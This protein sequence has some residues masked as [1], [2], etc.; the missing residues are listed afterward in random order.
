MEQYT[1]IG[2]PIPRNDAVEKATGESYYLN[3][4]SLPGL[5]YGK[6]LRS[7][8][9]HAEILEIDTRAAV[10]LDGVRAV[11]T[12][13]DVPEQKFSFIE[14]LSD[15]Y[16]L[17]KEKVRYIGDEVAAVAAID[18]ET[19]ER[20]LSLIKV[21]YKPLEAVFDPE[22]ALAKNAPRIHGRKSN[23]AY[24]IHEE[25]GDV[26]RGFADSDDTFEDEYRTQMVAHCCM[27]PRGCIAHYS[28]G[29][30]LTLWSPTQAPH[31]LREELA[32]VLGIPRHHVKVIKP[33]VGGA[34]GSRLVMDMKEPIAAILSRN[35]G[36][37]VKIVNSREEEFETA[38]IR[39]PFIIRIKTGLKKDG[40]ILARQ[41]KVVADNGAYSDKGPRIIS[42]AL[43]FLSVLYNVPN[44]KFDGYLVYTNKEHGTA[45][46]GFGNPQMH[47]A[48][49]SQLD[50]IAE[51]LGMDPMEIRLK[52]VNKPDEVT[53]SGARIG[54]CGLE[55]C[56]FTAAEESKWS[57][58][59]KRMQHS[60]R[61]GMGMAVMVHAGGG[62]R[63]YGYSAS[64]AFIKVSEDGLVTLISSATEVGQG[65][66]TAMA[67]IV[68]EELGV[69]FE[70]VVV[71]GD[72]TDISPFDLGCFGSRT[73]Y[74]CGNA[75]LDCAR[76]TKQEVFEIAAEM[77]E[78]KPDEIIASEGQIWVRGE[79]SRGV[80]FAEVAQFAVKRRGRP[81][82]GKGR[83]FDPMAI[84]AQK[85][86][87]GERMPVFSF[88]CQIAE[89]EVDVETGQVD[90][91]NLVAV[92]D[93]GAPINVLTA[94]GQIEG[95]LAQGMGFCLMENLVLERGK[96]INSNFADYKIPTAFDVP[97]FKTFF[98]DIHEPMG[99]FG[100]KGVGEPGL[101]AT[102][103]AI[104]NAIYD[105]IGVR[106]KELPITPEKILEA[107]EKKRMEKE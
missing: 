10:Q 38:K 56:I 25:F 42:T 65:A 9:P 36:R 90:L 46:R 78:S 100:A 105:A 59:K 34:F 53:T 101:V 5:L 20:A 98:V 73:T 39:Y 69:L 11:I 87:I 60:K 81:I 79:P 12:G 48:M 23:V 61:R 16:I 63:A 18:A 51:T 86:K 71:I 29:G 106:F 72:D 94:E 45:F 85:K 3:D 22:Q 44:I 21:I 17:S 88:A 91:L 58:G 41:V 55:A 19:A 89:V 27:E 67:Q 64:D 96:I 75:A 7:P 104:A 47:F 8:Y 74:V 37:P 4:L 70:D 84:G 1:L 15:Q 103:P 92:H 77:L 80:S 6:I 102:A 99:P 24:E 97:R 2:K 35:T 13:K 32:R 28:K 57:Y 26:E 49:E 93:T 43:L 66:K 33:V 68:A 107:L 30:R 76:N 95:S 14:E 62:G 50:M 54:S 31:T 83:F 82:S 40:R 52:N